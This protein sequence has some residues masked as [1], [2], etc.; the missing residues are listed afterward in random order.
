MPFGKCTIFWKWTRQQPCRLLQNQ[1]L[2]D[3]GT[4]AY[5]L[6][7]KIIDLV[8][9]TGENRQQPVTLQLLLATKFVTLILHNIAD[10]NNR[11]PVIKLVF[12]LLP[13]ARY[14]LQSDNLEKQD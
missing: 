5:G 2:P 1:H 7:P 9:L 14:T 4:E 8:I 10:E 3:R 12:Q 13:S 6:V 11:I